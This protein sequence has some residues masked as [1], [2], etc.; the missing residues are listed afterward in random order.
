[1]NADI[2]EAFETRIAT[3]AAAQTPALPVAWENTS[4]T[5]SPLVAYLRCAMLPA[6]TVNPA[7]GTKFDRLVGFYQINVYGTQDSGPA[8]AEAVADAII[9]LFPRG[10]MTQNG[11]LIN[12]DTTGSRAQGL[13]DINGFF[14]IPVRIRYRQDVIS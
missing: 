5:P 9:A 4:Y 12:I 10:G 6:P 7:L 11:T 1:M 2:R 3:F 14:F 13:N 8:A